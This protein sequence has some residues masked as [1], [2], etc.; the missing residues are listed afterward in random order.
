M[1]RPA[2]PVL[3][4]ALAALIP[5]AQPSAIPA[6][7]PASL[8]VGAMASHLPAV[9]AAPAATHLA[10]QTMQGDLSNPVWATLAAMGRTPAQWAIALTTDIDA[11]GRTDFL[12]QAALVAVASGQSGLPAEILVR[13]DA[14]ALA[15]VLQ[16]SP[17]ATPIPAAG[18]VFVTWPLGQLD[19]L[20][21]TGV[22]QM[23]WEPRVAA[24]A[25][26]N[27]SGGS[28]S[29]LPQHSQSQVGSA[30]SSGYHGAGV[31]IAVIDTGADIGHDA[32]DGGKVTAFKDCVGTGTT[33]YDDHGHG[34]HVAS[35]AAGDDGT[36]FKGVA[37]QASVV[38]IKVLDSA[39]SGNLGGLQCAANYVRT[40]G[41]GGAKTADIATM[42]AGITVP[43][44]GITTLNGG[45]FDLFGWDSVAALIP[46]SGIPFTVAAGNHVGMLFEFLGVDESTR[47]G[48][49]G[50]NQVSSPGYSKAVMTVGAVDEYRAEA[51]FSAL[52]PGEGRS[53]KPNVAAQ[54]KATW[55]ALAGT[56]HSYEQWD[57]TS[58]A[59]PI[60]AGVL[61]LEKGKNA[62]AS[63][64]TLEAAL[65]TGARSS[66][67]YGGSGGCTLSQPVRPNFVDGYGVVQAA[68][69][70]ALV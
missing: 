20:Q 28:P 6:A 48:I 34:T 11:N 21:A 40:G 8:S 13:G 55:G 10:P 54:G 30:W 3:L 53:Y 66:C 52:G 41:A 23:V 57:G 38:A 61:A 58:M 36:D 63:R 50:Y 19:R 7:A 1:L 70:L 62:L 49:N 35:I 59:T 42:S 9:A 45:D 31:R 27:P 47:V 16:L 64:T 44:L 25:S 22:T 46:A 37:D 43:P 29:S 17:T 24:A 67:V 15:N 2:L 4:L 56:A 32:L 68:S 51:A 60:A 14:A 65:Q 5:A 69:S 12:D 26:T 18:G 39:G 33:S